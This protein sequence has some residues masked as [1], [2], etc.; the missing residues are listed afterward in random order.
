MV[1]DGVIQKIAAIAAREHGDARRA[2]D[3]LRV[4]AEISERHGN[5]K[6]TLNYI[7][8]AKNH[9]EKNT[10]LEILSTLPQQSKVVIAAIYQLEILAYKEITSGNI[11]EKYSELCTHLFIDQLSTRRVSDF[12]NELDVLGI[13]EANIV[14]KGRYGRTKKVK[15]TVPKKTILDSFSKEQEDFRNL[16]F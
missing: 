3:L 8:D 12:I 10:C 7:N 16:F 4:S 15:I 1:E 13:I 14:S 9:I 6:I 11:Y 2:L 5:N